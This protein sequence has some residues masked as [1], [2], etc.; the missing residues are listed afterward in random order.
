MWCLVRGAG[1]RVFS[2]CDNG[3]FVG[4][5][6]IHEAFGVRLRLNATNMCYI[7]MARL[8]RSEHR[9]QCN[10]CTFVG[11]SSELLERCLFG[12]TKR[13]GGLRYNVGLQIFLPCWWKRRWTC[14]VICWIHCVVRA[15]AN[16]WTGADF[17]EEH[18]AG[19][20]AGVYVV[21]SVDC[22]AFIKGLNSSCVLEVCISSGLG[23]T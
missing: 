18:W 21:C 1:P 16:V 9:K 22:S 15:N 4:S 13:P 6:R 19:A 23:F 20:G 5:V 10:G 3:C 17:V 7:I 12:R 2:K 11:R 14:L 8:V